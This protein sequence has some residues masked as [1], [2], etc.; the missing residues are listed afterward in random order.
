MSEDL[1]LVRSIF[2]AWERPPV[3]KP[4]ES[5]LCDVPGSGVRAGLVRGFERGLYANCRG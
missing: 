3:R 4:V 1:D 2:A 5:G